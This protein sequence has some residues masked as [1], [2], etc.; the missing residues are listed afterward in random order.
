M[1]H[2]ST[3]SREPLV[4]LGILGPHA[5][6][7]NQVGTGYGTTGLLVLII[8]EQVGKYGTFVILHPKSSPFEPKHT[9]HPANPSM[10]AGSPWVL[11]AVGSLPMVPRQSWRH[12]KSWGKAKGIAPEQKEFLVWLSTC[13]CVL[14]F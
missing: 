3:E 9:E 8:H 11:Q 6:R 5:G 10:P 12:C 2:S 7:V 1:K 14:Q 4:L 13:E